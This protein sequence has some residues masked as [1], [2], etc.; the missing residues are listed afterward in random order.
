MADE[1]PEADLK[2]DNVHNRWGCSIMKWQH[3]VLSMRNSK[4]EAL[5]LLLC[6]GCRRCDGQ[7]LAGLLFGLCRLQY[8]PTTAW[9]DRFTGTLANKIEL[10]PPETYNEIVSLLKLMGYDC[11]TK[12]FAWVMDSAAVELMRCSV[13]RT[14]SSSCGGIASAVDSTSSGCVERRKQTALA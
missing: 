12:P 1:D 4:V 5:L 6:C 13:D 3:G 11:S 14:T 10:V 8:N 2:D 7:D 9:L